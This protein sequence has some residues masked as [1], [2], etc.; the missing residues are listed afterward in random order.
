MSN[1]TLRN[2]SINIAKGNKSKRQSNTFK[3]IGKRQLAVVIEDDGILKARISFQKNKDDDIIEYLVLP[4]TDRSFDLKDK[5]FVCFKE[6]D[7]YNKRVW[8]IRDKRK[9]ALFYG[10]SDIYKTLDKGLL[11]AGHIVKQNNKQYFDYE[12]L[13][14]FHEQGAHINA[15][16]DND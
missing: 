8:I 15:I 4:F 6:R 11:I 5:I 10:S 16:E 14:A 3:P 2:F 1:I 12:K 9:A 7:K 13:I